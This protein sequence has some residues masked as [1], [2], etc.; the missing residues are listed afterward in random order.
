M[1]KPMNRH[2]PPSTSHERRT[3]TETTIE[4]QQT[5]TQGDGM[6][7]EKLKWENRYWVVIQARVVFTDIRSE[8]LVVGPLISL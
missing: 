5:T 4:L 6:P 1:W 2:N 7:L 8:L 3:G